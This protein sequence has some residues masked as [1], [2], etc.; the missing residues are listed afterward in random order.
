MV[1][2]VNVHFRGQ[3]RTGLPLMLTWRALL[4][5]PLIRP[6]AGLIP[7]V[8]RR[9]LLLLLS[10]SLRAADPDSASRMLVARCTWNERGVFPLVVFTKAGSQIGLSIW[11]V[12]Q[13]VRSHGIWAAF[14]L[15]EV[16]SDL[17]TFPDA[18]VLLM[19]SIARAFYE[20]V[21]TLAYSS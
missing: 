3:C 13:S 8:I 6:V 18:D 17:K 11:R 14:L 12:P 15:V 16:S 10:W 5:N 1:I 9:S 20:S 19:R 7:N 2:R 4:L 21:Y